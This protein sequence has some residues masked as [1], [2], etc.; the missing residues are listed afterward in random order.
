M[1]DWS[2]PRII[3]CSLYSNT[4][5]FYQFSLSQ[6]QHFQTCFPLSAT[7]PTPKFSNSWLP[8]I[9]QSPRTTPKHWSFLITQSKVIFLLSPSLNKNSPIRENH[10]SE[11]MSRHPFVYPLIVNEVKVK[12]AQSCLTLRNPTDYTVRGIL[13]ARILE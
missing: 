9:F 2:R 13:Q 5:A 6:L 3:S 11:C 12:V 4:L 10:S 7:L 8:F 1:Q